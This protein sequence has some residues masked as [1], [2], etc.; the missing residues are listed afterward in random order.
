MSELTFEQRTAIMMQVRIVK[1]A[2]DSLLE[3]LPDEQQMVGS[4]CQRIDSAAN[5]IHHKYIAQGKIDAAATKTPEKG[6]HLR[7]P[8]NSGNVESTENARLRAALR[9]VLAVDEWECGDY[10]AEVNRIA[11]EALEEATDEE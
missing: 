3:L 8:A 2:V 1:A 4:E 6:A 9:E 7:N 5:E 10:K 11:R